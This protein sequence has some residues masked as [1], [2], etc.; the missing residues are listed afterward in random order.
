M[1]GRSWRAVAL[2]SIS[3]YTQKVTPLTLKERGGPLECRSMFRTEFRQY[4][5]SYLAPI[6]KKGDEFSLRFRRR[7][8]EGSYSDPKDE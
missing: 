7:F 2:M 5:D 4:W 1:K 6:A 8:F 3:F